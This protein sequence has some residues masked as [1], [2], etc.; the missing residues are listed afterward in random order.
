[1]AKS[2]PQCGTDNSDSA[3]FCRQ[4]AVPIRESASRCS[5][6]HTIAPGQSKCLICE[7]DKQGR[8][9]R[10]EEPASAP[11]FAD[12]SFKNYPPSK[13]GRSGI[14][15]LPDAGTPD[16][17]PRGM[18]TS[19]MILSAPAPR[20]DGAEPAQD[21]KIV[22]VLITYSTRPDGIIFPVREGRNRIGRN[23]ENEISIPNDTAM[24][25]LNSY[26]IFH[27]QGRKLFVIDDANSQ[28]GTYVNGEIVEERTRLNNYAEVRA[29]STVFTFLAARSSPRFG[30]E[31]LL[32]ESVY[33]TDLSSL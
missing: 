28:N 26:I 12:N 23:S 6:G 8:A 2:C 20:A 9:T 11:A 33:G 30:T 18:R 3:R 10:V 24:S 1:M 5:N 17:G 14:Q 31:E 25:G 32:K 19:T 29:G 7:A 13:G 22:G 15:V 21:R 4:C 16:A 27:P